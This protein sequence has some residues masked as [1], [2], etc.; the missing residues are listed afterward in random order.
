[1]SARS[2]RCFLQK[3]EWAIALFLLFSKERPKE[4]S[5]FCSFKK[6][7][8]KSERAKMSEKWAIFQN[9]HF[10]LKKKSDRSFS[11]WVNAQPWGNVRNKSYCGLLWATTLIIVLWWHLIIC[12]CTVQYICTLYNV[13]QL[14]KPNQDHFSPNLSREIWG[15]EATVVYYQLQFLLSFCDGIY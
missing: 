7:D 1:M 2:F 15:R 8:K 12:L 10:S 11:K 14:T 5:L 3:S 6:S 4:R 13:S 9:A